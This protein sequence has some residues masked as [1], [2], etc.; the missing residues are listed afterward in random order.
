MAIVF[1][2]KIPGFHCSCKDDD[3]RADGSGGMDIPDRDRDQIQSKRGA[4]MRGTCLKLIP[5]AG[6]KF[7]RVIINPETDPYRVITVFFDRRV[8]P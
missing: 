3:A 1:H 8:K 7:L 5:E 6:G 2:G 4:G